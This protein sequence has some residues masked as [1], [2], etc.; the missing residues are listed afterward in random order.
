[1]VTNRVAH[2]TS[3]QV[4][5]DFSGTTQPGGETTL[6]RC[7]VGRNGRASPSKAP[8]DAI[9]PRRFPLFSTERNRF[10]L[11]GMNHAAPLLGGRTQDTPGVVCV[12]AHVK[13]VRRWEVELALVEAL[14]DGL[15]DFSHVELRRTEGYRRQRPSNRSQCKHL[16]W[17]RSHSRGSLLLS[18]AHFTTWMS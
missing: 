17:S 6:Q 10:P 12:G 18:M 4:L 1:M 8:E 9:C 15:C 5:R 3:V 2:V 16:T 14:K 7:I 11:L 13:L